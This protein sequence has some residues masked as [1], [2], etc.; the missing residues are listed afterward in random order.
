M[1]SKTQGKRVSRGPGGRG[2]EQLEGNGKERHQAG[3]GYLAH[4]KDSCAG[5]K[6]DKK[7]QGKEPATTSFNSVR[8]GKEKNWKRE[9]MW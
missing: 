2:K 4:V 6:G 8:L 5:G 1:S 7:R 3:G 9:D